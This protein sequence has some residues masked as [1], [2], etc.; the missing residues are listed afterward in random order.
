MTEPS[1]SE[2][3]RDVPTLSRRLPFTFTFTVPSVLRCRVIDSVTLTYMQFTVVKE[4]EN[5][6]GFGT[7]PIALSA[8]RRCVWR[9]IGGAREAAGARHAAVLVAYWHSR[10]R[11]CAVVEQEPCLGVWRCVRARRVS[12]DVCVASRELHAVHASTRVSVVFRLS[13]QISVSVPCCTSLQDTG[14]TWTP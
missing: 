8:A 5:V 7:P 3:S 14:N 13:T 10:M 1:D 9:P 12:C 6:K 2:A 11:G 4:T